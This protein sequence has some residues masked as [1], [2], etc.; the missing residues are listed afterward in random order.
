MDSTSTLPSNV[1]G[2][3][4]VEVD[5]K[6]SRLITSLQPIDSVPVLGRV[7]RGSAE[8]RRDG[9]LGDLPR[10]RGGSPTRA[11]SQRVTDR[12]DPGRCAGSRDVAVKVNAWG[13]RSR[14]RR[15]RRWGARS[16]RGLVMNDESPGLG[17]RPADLERA[18][19]AG[20]PQ[21]HLLRGRSEDGALALGS[22]HS[23]QVLDESAALP[24]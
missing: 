1:K 24:S 21:P 8:H 18:A 6:V 7:E 4:D 3:V 20:H 15:R 9:L 12:Y 16:R 14:R 19:R 5:V 17:R 2:W 22:H 11:S 23:S 13:Q 10:P